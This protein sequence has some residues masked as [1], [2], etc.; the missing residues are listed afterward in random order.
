MKSNA[1]KFFFSDFTRENY[2]RLIRLAKEKYVF[3]NYNDFNNQERFILWRHDVDFSMHG[4]VKLAKIEAEEG[5]AATYLL[6]LHSPFYNLL[7]H[8]ITTCVRE[9]IGLGH[10][11]GLHFDTSYYQIRNEKEMFK[12]LTWEKG[13]LGDLFAQN[14]SVFSFHDPSNI[15]Q[16]FPDLMYEGMVNTYSQYFQTKVGYCS[17]SNGYWRFRRLENVLQESSDYSLQ[18]LTHPE[19]WQDVVMSPKQR[20]KHCI[21]GRAAKTEAWYAEVAM[22]SG[23]ENIDWN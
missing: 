12:W 2:R 22:R 10:I 3:R 21:D 9:I 23:R 6:L 11:I 8:E 7:E 15:L 13:I 14:I 16:K 20:L 17:D 19:W 4:S 5:V 1:E 18:V